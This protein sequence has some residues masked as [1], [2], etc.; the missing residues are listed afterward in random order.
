MLMHARRSAPS[1]T[2]LCA[3]RRILYC[4]SA[5]PPVPGQHASDDSLGIMFP[6]SK[7]LSISHWSGP[8]SW[9]A[10][11]AMGLADRGIRMRSFIPGPKIQW[12]W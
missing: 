8:V 10:Y 4:Q 1:W 3:V 12:N 6:T 5:S 9:F 7:E 11:L 2:M